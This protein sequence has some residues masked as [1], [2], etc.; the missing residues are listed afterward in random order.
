[1][2]V[3]APPIWGAMGPG[4][5]AAGYG[6]EM[7]PLVPRKSVPRSSQIRPWWAYYETIMGLPR[8]EYQHQEGNKTATPLRPSYGIR[9]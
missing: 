5:G 7:E 6:R 1:M 8:G 3:F 9:A 2:T 4:E